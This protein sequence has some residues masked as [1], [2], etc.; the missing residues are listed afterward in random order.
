M[1]LALQQLK[2]VDFSR[3][4][5]SVKHVS[6]PYNVCPDNGVETHYVGRI[7]LYDYFHNNRQHLRSSRISYP[8]CLDVLFLSPAE[9]LSQTESIPFAVSGSSLSTSLIV[10]PKFIQSSL[11]ER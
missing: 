10:S 2:V 5:A 8:F 11:A 7:D 4:Y 6:N 1:G 3:F 9:K